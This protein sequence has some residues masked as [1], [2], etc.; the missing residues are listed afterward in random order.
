MLMPTLALRQVLKL[1]QHTSKGMSSDLAVQSPE[2]FRPVLQLGPQHLGHESRPCSGAAVRLD[3]CLP[4]VCMIIVM[5]RNTSS[6]Q[7]ARPI[8]RCCRRRCLLAGIQQ[9]HPGPV[10]SP[11]HDRVLVRSVPGSRLRNNPDGPQVLLEL[12]AWPRKCCHWYREGC[13]IPAGPAGIQSVL[14]TLAGS[15]TCHGWQHAPSATFSRDLSVRRIC[16]R[17]LHGS[18]RPAWLCLTDSSPSSEADCLQSMINEPCTQQI[19]VYHSV[20]LHHLRCL[21]HRPHDAHAAIVFQ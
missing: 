5:P 6:A 17:A 10:I 21:C 19:Q 4:V 8:K 9:L 12:P 13:I 7:I 16:L 14:K 18:E 1:A 15:V 20:G 11:L 3:L 2:A